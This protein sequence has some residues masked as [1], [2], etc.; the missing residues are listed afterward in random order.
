MA[1][2]ITVSFLVS[3]TDADTIYICPGDGTSAVYTNT[4][5]K[6]CQAFLEG[7][8]AANPRSSGDGFVSGTPPRSSFAEPSAGVGIELNGPNIIHN[9]TGLSHFLGRLPGPGK[10][11]RNGVTVYHFGDSHVRSASFSR[12]TAKGLQQRFGD[13][14]GSFCYLK[15]ATSARTRHASSAPVTAAVQHRGGIPP[16]PEYLAGRNELWKKF[17]RGND[18]GPGGGG[19]AAP[20][21]FSA[22]PAR[23]EQPGSRDAADAGEVPALPEETCAPIGGGAGSV[24]SSLAPVQGQQ[25]YGVSYHAF[26]IP[27]K[28][29]DYFSRSGIMMRHLEK[30]RPDLIIITLGTNDAFAKL[31]YGDVLRH[32]ARLLS[33][34]RSVAPS[35]SILF[36]V[37]PDTFFRNGAN[38]RYT[39]GVRQAIIDFCLK[40]GCAWWDLYGIMGGAG[41]MSAWRERG[42]GHRDRIH[43]TSNG[44]RLTGELIAEAIL[45]SYNRSA[46]S[47]A[48]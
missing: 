13:G 41:S 28:T 33:A 40:N 25:S 32:L 37:P 44:Y 15:T 45:K 16:S 1:L 47:G 30:Y 27:G 26:G 11:A 34:I 31:D 6:G 14:G 36:T 17:S 20:A 2:A 43:F 18:D 22:N 23:V 39:P 5:G 29:I 12:A 38:N 24:I 10:V 48:K 8:D 42:L 19:E 46:A 4:P 7:D 21:T 9:D 35:A 3:D